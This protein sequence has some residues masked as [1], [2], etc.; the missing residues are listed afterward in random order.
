MKDSVTVF[1][2]TL[3]V[4]AMILA[5]GRLPEKTQSISLKPFV[6]LVVLMT[7]SLPAEFP[8]KMHDVTDG[9]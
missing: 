6:V 1:V 8:L 7:S 3:L 9:A 2:K 5:F 4:K